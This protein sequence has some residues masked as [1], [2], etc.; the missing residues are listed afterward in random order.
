MGLEPR[1][2]RKMSV[3]SE[4]DAFLSRPLAPKGVETHLSPGPVCAGA[5][6]ANLLVVSDLH[7]GDSLRTAGVSSFRTLA[8]LNR[9]FRRFLE[10]YGQHPVGGRPWKLVIN[11][12]MIDFLHAGVVNVRS[13]AG[14][15]AS[16]LSEGAALSWL[17][18]VMGRERRVFRALASFVARGHELVIIT[19]NHDAQ[20]H[21]SRVQLSLTERLIDIHVASLAREGDTHP[22]ELGELR[23]TMRS[24]ISFCPWFYYEKDVVYIEHGHQYDEFCSFE[25]V[26]S[27]I[28]S[29]FEELEDPISHRTYREFANLIGELDVH[30]IDKWTFGDYIQWLAGLAPR[31]IGRLAYTY[32]A[33]VSWLVKTKRRLSR[34]AKRGR[35]EH[36]CRLKKMTRRFNLSEELLHRLDALRERPAGSRVFSGLR[37]LYLDRFVLLLLIAT[38][39]AAVFFAPGSAWIRSWSGLGVLLGALTTNC[40]LDRIRKVDSHPKLIPIA[41]KVARLM[42][43]PFVIFGHSHVPVASE[44]QGSTLSSG[45]GPKSAH[46]S[47]KYFNTG[48]W[49]AGLE[50]GL[51]HVCI[52]RKDSEPVAELRRWCTQSKRPRA[53]VLSPEHATPGQD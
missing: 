22:S 3:T 42:K 28:H 34:V 50:K 52:L 2:G 36:L 51:T 20:F 15:E 37:M 10:H 48:S 40:F 33:S 53:L 23:D 32:F 25:H 9:A 35:R 26:L 17:E 49:T 29:G 19:G 44:R 30:R 13:E 1:W 38:V 46:P 39:L 4:P 43:V 41:H 24:R 45:E 14:E 47:S 5:Q 6:G 12:D 8:R 16:A 27:P 31:V 18:T 21:W 7:L 11:G